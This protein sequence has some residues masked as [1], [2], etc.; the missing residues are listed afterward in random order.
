M[1]NDVDGGLLGIV[2]QARSTGYGG[3]GSYDVAIDGVHVLHNTVD[4]AAWYGI[5]ILSFTGH[6]TDFS[7]IT[8]ASSLLTS[9]GIS[10]NTVTDSGGAAVLFWAYNNEATAKNGRINNNV[11]NSLLNKPG[12]LVLESGFGQ[13]GTVQNV[14][15]VNNTFDADTNPQI[16]DQGEDTKIPPGP[17]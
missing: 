8:G 9:V 7:P 1:K 13:Q 3:T 15:I 10:K 12:I 11:I 16:S 4:N 5:Y 2:V 14:K 6:P 17:F